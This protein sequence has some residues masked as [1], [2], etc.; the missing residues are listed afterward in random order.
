MDG[1][2]FE[3]GQRE[4]DRLKVLHE[5]SKRQ[6]TQRHAAEQLGITERQVRRLLARMRTVGDLAV[7]H[8]LRDRRSNRRI[9]SKV[10]QRAVAEL[11]KPEC[12]DFGPTYGAEHV[13]KQ[14][15]I[16]AGKDTVR[17]WMISAG[18]WLSRKRECVKVH[19]WRRRRAC[20]GELVQ[21][22][23]SVARLAGRAG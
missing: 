19:S 13:R 11:S 6:I 7:V 2:R 5:A 16:Q 21:W 18:L 17:Q 15:G 9:D 14:L 20:F 8:G 4:R 22:D 10:E 23:T 12:R 1:D 3:V